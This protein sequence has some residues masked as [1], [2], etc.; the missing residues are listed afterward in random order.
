MKPLHLLNIFALSLGSLFLLFFSAVFYM[1][2]KEG[3]DELVKNLP[4]AFF[5]R[6]VG[7]VF[8]SLIFAALL[9]AFNFMILVFQD[10]RKTQA[11]D[12]T[13]KAALLFMVCALAGTSIFFFH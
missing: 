10:A 7:F 8:L 2:S 9:G 11:I 1:G 12:I 6:F 13:V 3:Y 5:L 4:Q